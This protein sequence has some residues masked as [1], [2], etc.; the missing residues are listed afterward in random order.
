MKP[1]SAGQDCLV[2]LQLV[3][4]CDAAK[5]TNAR[6]ADAA[7]NMISILNHRG[8]RLIEVPIY[9]WTREAMLICNEWRTGL[10][11]YPRG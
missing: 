11:I 7:N 2:G 1:G 9:S 8:E 3:N 10:K 4:V 5:G 6:R